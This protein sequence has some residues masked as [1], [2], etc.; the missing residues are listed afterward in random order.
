MPLGIYAASIT[1]VPRDD[2]L[3]LLSLAGLCIPA[4]FLGILLILLFGVQLRWLPAIGGGNPDAPAGFARLPGAA[5][6]HA[7]V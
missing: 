1:T 5:S 3:R 6:A 2:L 7:W 4:F